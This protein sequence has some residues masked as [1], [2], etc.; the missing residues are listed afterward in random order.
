[1]NKIKPI[2]FVASPLAGD[3]ELMN[4]DFARRVCREI[5]LNTSAMPFAPHLL[6]PQF[7][8]DKD[9]VERNLGI[10]YCSTALDAS[11]FAAFAVPKWRPGL[12]TG[13]KFERVEAESLNRRY[14]IGI[15]RDNANE[16]GGMNL[17]RLIQN[18]AK[19][20]PR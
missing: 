7:L 12:S 8:N 9:P 13:M 2:V 4:I 16:V 20:F 15:D 10:S 6:F 5:A 17:E 3:D 11:R 18:L 1:M 19:R 14:E